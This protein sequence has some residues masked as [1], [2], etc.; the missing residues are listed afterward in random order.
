MRRAAG[1]LDPDAALDELFAA[2]ARAPAAAGFGLRSGMPF[3][4][5]YGHA[6]LPPEH[7]V[8]AGWRRQAPGLDVLVCSTT[9]EAAFFLE[10]SPRLRSVAAKPVIG[11]V[12][13]FGLVRAVTGAVYTWGGRRFARLLPR[14]RARVQAPNSMDAPQA[15]ASARPTPSTSRC[16]SQSDRVGP[17]TAPG[18]ARRDARR[19]GR[20]DARRVGEFARTG[21]IAAS[22]IASAPAGSEACGCAGPATAC[23]CPGRPPRASALSPATRRIPQ[24]SDSSAAR[25]SHTRRE[26]RLHG[27]R[28]AP[29]PVGVGHPD[30]RGGDEDPA[31]R[32]GVRGR[33]APRRG[34]RRA[35]SAARSAGSPPRRARGTGIAERARAAWRAGRSRTGRR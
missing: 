34:S 35:P 11:P 3:S 22:R 4:P 33:P 28:R 31:W 5:Q 13:R 25:S 27:W 2:Q 8:A 14:S 18:A 16:C 32:T 26:S 23:R 19:G 12:I 30:D 6:P 15:A 24:R 17:G 1:P 10:L 7:E 9:E 29:H 21:R 20:A